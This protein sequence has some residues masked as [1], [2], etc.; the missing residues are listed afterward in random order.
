MQQSLRPLW[1]H[2]I[3]AIRKA[4]TEKDLFL[5]MEMG[6][7]KTRCTIEVLRRRYAKRGVLVKTLII[8]PVI[9][10]DNWKKEWAMFSK[11][12]AHDVVVLTTAGK[13][14]VQDLLKAVGDDL[15]RAK[16]VITN[17]Q[18]L[19]MGDLYKLIR[20]WG[21]EIVVFDES[22]KLKNPSSKT[23]KLANALAADAKQKFLLTGT[24]ILNSP[25]DLWSQYKVLDNGETFGSNFYSF[26]ATYFR[27]ENAGWSS[28]ENHFP[29]WTTT[30][31]ML[32]KITEK[33]QHKM[34]RVTKAECMDLPD[35]VRQEIPVVL[36]AEQA[37]M[38]SEMKKEFLAFL[39]DSETRHPL[40]VVAQLAITKALRLQQIVS[41]YA[42]TEQEG[43]KW[44]KDNP[45]LHVL[46]ELLETITPGHK[47]IVWSVFKENYKMITGLCEK[48]GLEFAQIHGD[49]SN[50]DRIEEMDRFKSDPKCR[51]MV[52]NQAAGGV[53]INLVEASYSIYYSKGFSLEHDLQSEARNHRGGSEI[54]EKITRIDLVAAGTIDELI[55]E[56]LS[57]KL[58]CANL[59]LNWK[60]KI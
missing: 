28:K 59:I 40:T 11:I 38:Y 48:M 33:L 14:R 18:G 24:P 50:K 21:P 46:E 8:C 47:V 60:E 43:A 31:E 15:S 4:E 35:L 3:S 16:I 30:P 49:I 52:A 37:R 51:V 56:A 7:G 39:K 45:R 57:K 29:K 22:H 41:G 26:R 5:A 44:I 2:Q 32:A 34:I 42:A 17:Y 9:V 19:L 12:P 55:N 23:F 58:N 25:M 53:G 20:A 13:R 27:D 10:C 54:H 6:T 1:A 36:S